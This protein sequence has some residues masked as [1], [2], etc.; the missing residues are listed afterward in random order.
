MKS[1]EDV[2]A[3]LKSLKGELSTRFF[4]R[5]IGIF[6]SV[7]RHEQTDES[8]IDVLVE[9]DRPVGFF[10]FIELEDYL[11]DHLGSPVDLVTPDAL[12]PL[13]RETVTNEVA[14]A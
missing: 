9:F 2:L 12:K 1:R 7:A 6:G 5:R 4:V 3:I 10:T 11:A 14:Y 13:V 8:D